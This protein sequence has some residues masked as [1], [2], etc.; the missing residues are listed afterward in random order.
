MQILDC[1]NYA[2]SQTVAFLFIILFHGIQYE[3]AIYKIWVV[4][5]NVFF[6]SIERGWGIHCYI[7]WTWNWIG[8]NWCAFRLSTLVKCN[9]VQL[10]AQLWR[11]GN[12]SCD[13]RCVH[14]LSVCVRGEFY[15]PC[16]KW[17]LNDKT[18][19]LSFACNLLRKIRHIWCKPVIY[20]QRNVKHIPPNIDEN[21][22]QQFAT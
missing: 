4:Q 14:T 18:V 3:H 6:L 2:A 7:Q 15:T 21:V 1:D 5:R 13:K 8:K 12:F 9:E 20:H 19:L 11:I 16:G 17:T 22:R 10:L